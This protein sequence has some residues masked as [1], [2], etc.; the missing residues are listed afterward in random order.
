MLRIN[1]ANV[2]VP[3]VC[4]SR[5]TPP[6]QTSAAGTPACGKSDAPAHRTHTRGASPPPSSPHHWPRVEHLPP[7]PRCFQWMS[8]YFHLSLLVSLFTFVT[9]STGSIGISHF[10]GDRCSSGVA[11]LLQVKRRIKTCSYL[12]YNF[13]MA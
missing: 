9:E 13:H 2:I 8:P 1:R 7:W 11:S 3:S 10:S 12:S 6:A 4:Y 5:R